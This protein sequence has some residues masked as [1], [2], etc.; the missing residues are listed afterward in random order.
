MLAIALVLEGSDRKTAA[1]TCGMDRQTLRDWVHR[2][3]AEGIEGLS[4]RHSA[5]PTPLLSPNRRRNWRRLSVMG[6]TLRS[7]GWSAG[8]A[9]TSSARSKTALAWSCM[10]E[11]SVSSLRRS[12]FAVCRCAPSTQSPTRLRRR[13]SKKLCRDSKGRPLGRGARQAPGGLVSR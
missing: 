7:T 1:E 9:A 13:R 12:G 6:L 11:R 5:G 2:Y 8:A 10:S 4:N 3:N